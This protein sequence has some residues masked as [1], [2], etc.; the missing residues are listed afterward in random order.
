MSSTARSESHKQPSALCNFLKR[1]HQLALRLATHLEEESFKSIAIET[2]Y[3]SETVRRY[4]NGY[5]KIPADFVTQIVRI[6]KLNIF[7]LLDI[8]RTIELDDLESVASDLLI[9]ELARRFSRVE[10]C[11]IASLVVN[12]LSEDTQQRGSGP[13]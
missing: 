1:D 5:S 10:D 4:I 13:S 11:A 9:C 3:S 8:E 2:G 7:E 6:Y 12:S